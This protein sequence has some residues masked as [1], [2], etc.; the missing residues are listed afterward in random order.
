MSGAQPVAPSPSPSLTQ[1][2]VPAYNQQYAPRPS[3]SPAP[4]LQHHSSYGS[5]SSNLQ[6]NLAQSPAAYQS[7]QQYGNQYVSTPSTPV[8][9]SSLG[10][11]NSHYQNAAPAPRPV[12]QTSIPHN[13][14]AQAYNP[15]KQIEV[16]T[17]SDTA[18]AAIPADI[19]NQFHRDE[20]G[21]VIFYTAPPLDANP[22]PEEKQNLSHSLQYLADKARNKE[23]D[24]KKRK[25]HSLQLEAEAS[26]RLKRIKTDAEGKKQWLVDQKVAA[27]QSWC[28]D[29]DHGTDELYKKM[30][31]DDWKDVREFDVNKLAVLQAEEFIKKKELESFRKETLAKKDVKITGFKWI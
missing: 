6:T 21:R 9:V 29:M 30:H 17:L 8:A 7:Q 2:A 14:H 26:E 20:M 25:A 23:A 11:Y 1:A 18:N 22:I 16:Y 27:L 19:R 3:A 24:E 4:L 31:R 5:Q 12:I 13:S 10:N 15:P 28:A